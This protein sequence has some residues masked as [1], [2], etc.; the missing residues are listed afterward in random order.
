MKIK[1][2]EKL[3]FY[4]QNKNRFKQPRV[5]LG[6]GL[7]IVYS[8]LLIFLGGVV[9]KEGVFGEVLIPAV[10]E[11]VRIPF[12]Y[13]K[14]LMSEPEQL[15]VDIKYKNY[16]KLAFKRKE[17]LRDGVLHSFP[18]DYV[19][20]KIRWD[21]KTTKVKLRLKGDLS[22]HW[23]RDYKWSLRVKTKGEGTI[24]GMKN[25][26][27][28]HPRT[29][30]FFNDWVLHKIL[31]EEGLIALRYDFVDV[32]VNGK[33][34]GIYAIEEHFEQKLLENNQRVD[35]P[36][37][38]IKD[39][40]LWYLVDPKTGFTEDEIDE[41]YTVSP[42]D[43]FTS[44]KIKNDQR[45]RENFNTAKNLLEAFRRGK[46]KTSEV[47][48]ADKLAKLFAVIDLFGYR[49]TTA[50]SNIRFYY[51]P[52]TSRLEPIGYDN[53]FIHEVEPLDG[54]GIE[55]Q[56]KQIKTGGTADKKHLHWKDTF[57][58]DREFFEKYIVAVRKVSERKYL[59]DLFDKTADDFDAT[60]NKVYKSFPAYS[61]DEQK[62]LLY[63][64]QKIIN[65]ILNPLEGI[66]AY[67]KKIDRVN[68]AITLEL[69]NNQFLPILIRNISINGSVY[70]LPDNG[71]IILQAKVPF[72]AIKFHDIQVP[73]PEKINW[74]D[75]PDNDIKVNYSLLG[76]TEIKKIAAFAWSH[77]D[78]G[79]LEND[80][81][82]KKANIEEFSF[83]KIYENKKEIN[84]PAGKW[85]IDKNMYIPEGYAVLAGAETEL[86]IVDSSFIL[87]YSPLKFT[88]S[89]DSPVL[90]GS[91]DGTGQ[92]IL[93]LKAEDKSIL[94]NV[95]L[96]DISG[97]KQSGL[98]I[99]GA[100]TLYES[101]IDVSNVLFK[102]NKSDIDLYIVRSKFEID[103]SVFERSKQ[104]ALNAT[105][106]KGSVKN[107]AFISSGETAIEVTGSTVDAENIEIADAGR[108]GL[109]VKD[110][111]RVK[112]SDLVVSR[113]R[114]A[115]LS[116][117]SSVVDV[118]G[119]KIKNCK[120]AFSALQVKSEYGPAE[121]TVTGFDENKI[122]GSIL[123]EDKS[124]LLLD[125]KKYDTYT[126]NILEELNGS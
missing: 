23:A 46:L 38:R 67:V 95:V 8:S 98:D 56:G 100:L 52:F 111:G 117:S 60:I 71:E 15:I 32:I 87:S 116:Q 16:Q 57:F 26:S 108:N 44:T 47:F 11:N 1:E 35:G 107:S 58:E 88:G 50:Y 86:D 30:G 29:R 104:I 94:H 3:G 85:K 120:N 36:I 4:F 53:T 14:G 55:G 22:D 112:I 109:Y 82:R 66:Q 5:L 19:N 124:T 114:N 72:N 31:K 12:N 103:K 89:V 122:S 93:V 7:I 68:N 125:E 27:L 81:V 119:L 99:R 123:I 24:L 83:I 78:T 115:L 73:L 62:K 28:Q 92:G 63:K 9:H 65:M 121:I 59:D 42:I 84:I 91:S 51:N 76:N 18:E 110:K 61:F 41:L 77:L 96:K 13:L 97:P 10:R 34:L 79:F 17:A 70:R 75:G 20:A 101:D 33:N 90:I 54:R 25:F 113:T 45:L 106:S 118:D 40:L 43:A 126:K 74:L 64:N 69:G 49:H 2:S 39:H 105:Y 102:G 21:G 6:L 37:V 48:D 80:V